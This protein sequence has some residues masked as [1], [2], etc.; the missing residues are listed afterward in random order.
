M[1]AWENSC[2]FLSVYEVFH[3]QKVTYTSVD[4]FALTSGTTFCVLFLLYLSNP[5]QLFCLYIH[6]KEISMSFCR[7]LIFFFFHFSTVYVCREIQNIA[8]LM[9]RCEG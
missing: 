7:H 3:V 2:A 5:V 6:R 9:Y 8:D 1:W 4:S